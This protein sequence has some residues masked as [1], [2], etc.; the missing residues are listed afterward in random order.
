[1]SSARG[2]SRIDRHLNVDFQYIKELISQAGPEGLIRSQRPGRKVKGGWEAQS[3][4]GN[5]I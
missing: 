5:M 4:I 3:R 2:Y 1:V